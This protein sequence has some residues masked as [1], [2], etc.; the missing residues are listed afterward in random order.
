[1]PWIGPLRRLARE[2]RAGAFFAGGR[3]GL[4][5]REPDTDFLLDTFL[6]TAFLLVDFVVVVFLRETVFATAFLL[7]VDLLA[8]VFFLAG[9]FLLAAFFRDAFFR[10]A[11]FFRVADVV[12][13]L[14]AVRFFEAFLLA[15]ALRVAAFLPEAGAFFRCLLAVFFAGIFYSCRTEKRRGLYMA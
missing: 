8:P 11:V 12:F 10:G 5:D 7:P 15:P 13:F 6:V 9:D 3:C 14:V 1:M 4:V 2:R